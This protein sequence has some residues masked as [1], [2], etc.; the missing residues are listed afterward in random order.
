MIT[1][2][3]IRTQVQQSIDGT[4]NA[5]TID[6]DG[7]VRDI[8]DTYGLVDTLTIEHYEYWAIIAHHDSTQV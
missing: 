2:H 1:D 3:D 7:V 5:E 8:I 4:D 6:V